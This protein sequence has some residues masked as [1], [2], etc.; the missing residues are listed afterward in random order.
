MNKVKLA[1][2][3]MSAAI[4]TGVSGHAGAQSVEVLHWWTSG[5]EADALATVRSAFTAAGGTWKDTPI[6][7]GGNARAAAVNRI[8]GGQPA[9]VFQFSIGAQ[10]SELAEQGLVGDVQAVADKAGWDKVLPPLVVTA[11]KY[12]GKYIAAPIDI[13]AENWMFYNQSVLDKAGVAVPKTWDEFIAAAAKIKAAGATPI[14]LGGQPWQERILFNSVL[15]GIGGRDFYLKVYRDLDEATMRSPQMLE[16]FKTVAALRPFVDEGAPGRRWN[17]AA[18]M[19]MRGQAAFQFMGDWAKGE[20]VAAG[21]EPGKG[22]GCALAPA[23]ETGYIMTVDAFAFAKSS[24]PKVL[25]AQAAVANTMMDPAV[26][27]AFNKKKGA[28]PVRTDIPDTEFDDC[29]KLGMKIV[30]DPA[31]HLLSTG[32]FGVSSAVSGAIDDAISQYWNKASAT[33]EQGRDLFIGAIKNAK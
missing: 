27:I 22:M 10:L 16:I 14:A 24:D 29:A 19:L 5:G 21:I 30:K 13:H 6:A 2:G 15:L 25:A 3:L 17:D 18:A 28:I 11:A 9:D 32:L 4:V 26:Q 23:K 1:A 20:F 7:G 33:P 31:N 8:I 12:K